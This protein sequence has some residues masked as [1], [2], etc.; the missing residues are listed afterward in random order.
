M[1]NESP[2]RPARGPRIEERIRY[3]GSDFPLPDT[4]ACEDCGDAPCTHPTTLYPGGTEG[5][6]FL[7]PVTLYSGDTTPGG[8]VS[9][10]RAVPPQTSP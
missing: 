8:P 4:G 7:T 3:L 9:R 10:A 2:G 1:R 5:D 6:P